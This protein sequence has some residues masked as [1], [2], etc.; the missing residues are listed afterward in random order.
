MALIHGGQLQQ[1][2]AKFKIPVNDWLDLSTGIAP[3]SYPIAEIP[4]HLWQQLPQA[5]ASL[6]DAA[7][8][9]YQCQTVLVTNG[10]QSIIK[11]LPQLWRL[12]NQHSNNV[13]LPAKGYKEH[14]HAWTNT[15]YQCHFY[16]DELPSLS[17][18]T[19][20]CVVVIINPNNPTGKLFNKSEIIRYQQALATLNGLLVVDEAFIDVIEPT[21]SISSLVTDSHT[22]VLRSFGKFFGLAGI[23]IG[24][25]IADEHWHQVFTEY[26]G[27]WQ[28][29]GPAQ[30]IAEQALLDHNWQQQQRDCLRLLQAEQRQLII[31]ALGLEFIANIAGT[32]LFLTVN[33]HQQFIAKDI[34]QLLCQQGVYVR[35]TDE[36]DC[37]RLGI[38]VSDNFPRLMKVLSEVKAQLI[39]NNKQK[40]V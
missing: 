24:F 30:Y 8:Q 16:Q 5:N 7:K 10:S 19:S 35:L 20:D 31:D 23:R 3:L 36:E 4:M 9:Y 13:Y 1:I 39:I 22:L 33:F 34:Y 37:L 29:N 27:P 38:T 14:A 28:V 21:Q 2:A 6:I 15:G 32:D 25:L 12:Q 40:S 26:L 18:L 17:Q 11:A